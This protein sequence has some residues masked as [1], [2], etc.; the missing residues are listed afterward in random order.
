MHTEYIILVLAER[1]GLIIAA[2]FLLLTFTPVERMGIEP[3]F[4]KYRTPLLTLFFGL[5]GILGTYTGNSVFQSVANLRAMAV[6]T[7][8]LFG[9]PVV[10]IGAG[11]IAGGHRILFD[12]HGFSAYPCGLATFTE[13]LAAGLIAWRYGRR[14]L[15]WKVAAPLALV[16]ES[17]HMG[18]VLLLS[19]PFPEAVELVKLI[20]PPMISVNTLAVVIMVELIN[21][22][23][24]SRERRDSLQAQQILDIANLTVSHLRAGLDQNS[25]QQTALIIHERVHMAAVA[26]TDTRNV[27][28]HVGA[29]SDH[30]LPGLPIHTQATRQVLET[31]KPRFITKRS[32]IGCDV[33]DCP[34]TSAII[35]PLTKAGQ[36]VGTL[37]FYGS[38]DSPLNATLFELCKGLGKLF[39]TQL[40]LED[41]RIKERM[42][43]HAEIRRLQAQI[44]PHFLFNS[45]NTIGSFCRTNAEKARELLLDLSFYMRKSLDSSRGFIP[46][47]DE[48]EQVRS[49][50]A[51]EQARFGHRIDVHLDI[52]GGC[53][54]WP[55]PPLIIQPLVE[56]SIKHGILGSKSGGSVEVRATL[57]GDRLHIR[58]TDNGRGM[59]KAQVHALL[60]KNGPTGRPGLDTC[61]AGIGIRN[62]ASRLE[63]IYGPDCQLDIDST[64]GKGTRISF[65]I[66][67]TPLSAAA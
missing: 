10:G 53:A 48:L 18:L 63:Q 1:L 5:F 59:D 27:L 45:L 42:L 32:S 55:I 33:P 35:V 66:P 15:S 13:G 26:V 56:N 30:H 28:A 38:N 49:Y 34:N 6:I 23:F 65:S 61:R 24:Q 52:E 39:S 21:V 60:D 7:G 36:I 62:C 25:A 64:P 19:R 12:L 3:S 14:A 43:A 54:D 17:L 4:S 8:G 9:G 41:L 22:F 46:L 44:N 20:A 2:V 50:L 51:I 58:V 37:K 11:L 57:A 29:G 16:G 40:E 31:G 67:R 47:S